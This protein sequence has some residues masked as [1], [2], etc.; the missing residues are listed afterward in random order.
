MVKDQ[1]KC[2]Y[3]RIH[4]LVLTLVCEAILVN[5]P[6]ASS[7]KHITVWRTDWCCHGRWD[8]V[9]WWWWTR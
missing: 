9:G 2:E 3:S 5:K 7:I 6:S 1:K 4:E 8:G